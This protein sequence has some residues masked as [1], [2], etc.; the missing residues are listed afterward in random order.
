[1]LTHLVNLV[2]SATKDSV[3]PSARSHEWPK[4]EKLHLSKFPACAACGSIK[5]P[6]VHH[7]KPFHLHPELEL[8]PTNL[9]TLCMDNDCHLLVGHGDNFRAYNPNVQEDAAYVNS[10][11]SELQLVLKEVSE[12]AKKQRLFE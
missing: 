5:K 2:K 4:V 1:M 8:D 9:I 7:M 10:H 12:K 6:Q 11:V 3:N